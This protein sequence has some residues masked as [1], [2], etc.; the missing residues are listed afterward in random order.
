MDVAGE[1]VVVFET[2]EKLVCR[3][4]FVERRHHF[5]VTRIEEAGGAD[6]VAGLVFPL[7]DAQ[8]AGLASECRIVTVAQLI[9]VQ[10]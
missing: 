2:A 5:A 9:T 3:D 7:S 8:E 4:A 1:V 10:K 6:V